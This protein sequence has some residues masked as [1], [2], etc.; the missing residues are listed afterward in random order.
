MGV[1]TNAAGQ[2]GGALA[3]VGVASRMIGDEK[4]QAIAHGA[5]AQQEALKVGEQM[6]ALKE[7]MDKA[8][9]QNENAAK[10]EAALRDLKISSPEDV[11]AFMELSD[12]VNLDKKMAE[13]ALDTVRGKIQ[14]R[15]ELLQRAEKAMAKGRSWGGA[16]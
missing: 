8:I 6:P 13:T 7:E 9:A 4:A 10:E 5:Q 12:G 1:G 3:A 11:D 15:T 14:A 2:L 16:F